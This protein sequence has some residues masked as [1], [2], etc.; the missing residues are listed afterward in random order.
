MAK[1]RGHYILD[2]ALIQK[3]ARLA[4]LGWSQKA[5]AE[6]CGVGES[7]LRRWL[8]NA[9][10][11]NATELEIALL[12][13]I[14][15]ALTA[16]EENLVAKIAKG[17]TRDAQW[18]LTHSARWRDRWSD[19]AATRREVNNVLTNV[20]QI[21]QQSELTQEQRDHLLLQMHAAGLGAVS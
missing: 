7:T 15:E 11:E 16:G 3:A 10:S 1:E 12:A 6:A 14:Q 2:E 18:L 19:A 8:T 5:I 20:V 17:D 21:I 9:E 13:A 4:A